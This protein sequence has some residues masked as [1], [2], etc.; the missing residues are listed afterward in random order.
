MSTVAQVHANRANAVHS[1]GP[2]T[3]A[4][5]AV[6]SRNATRH[7]LYSRELLLP[8]ED[9][10][11][12]AKLRQGMIHRLQPRDV[13]EQQVVDQ[14]IECSWKLKRLHAAEQE[15]YLQQSLQMKSEL[16][17]HLQEQNVPTNEPLP[18]PAI[19]LVTWRLLEAGAKS[20]LERLNRQQQRLWNQM[21]KCLKD[22]AALQ[23]Q[24]LTPA[25]S[26]DEAG[27]QNEP[28]LD[29]ATGISANGQELY[30]VAH[31]VCNQR[32]AESASPADPDIASPPP[33][34]PRTA[35]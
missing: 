31:E 30:R 34:T 29:A 21:Q 16:R 20:P 32:P 25:P 7:G 18:E 3:D 24:V 9:A 1:T 12:F 27:V 22:L 6:S 35:A 33:A 26:E 14:Y 5:K 8:G 23:Q 15:A 13:M 28:N 19:G 17:A 4:G 2:K 10:A 11:E